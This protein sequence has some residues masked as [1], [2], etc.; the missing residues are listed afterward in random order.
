MFRR[1]G[2]PGGGG[3]QGT[4]PSAW[5]LG[6]PA[7]RGLCDNIAERVVIVERKL[8]EWAPKAYWCE[9]VSQHPEL[10]QRIP[11]YYKVS[12]SICAI[13]LRM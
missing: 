13:L 1:E 8:K 5:Q 10:L 7:S 4:R 9:L 6:G 2:D 3:L 11:D 12:T